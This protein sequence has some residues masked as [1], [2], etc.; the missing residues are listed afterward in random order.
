VTDRP[1]R[2][3]RALV[4]TGGSGASADGPPPKR[5]IPFILHQFLEYAVGVALVVL[6]VHLGKSDLLLGAGA[7]FGLLAVTAH[8]PL[9]I[10]R[11]C[12][13][14][15]HRALDVAVAIA[16]ALSPL[17]GTLRPGVVGIVVVELVAVAWLRVATLTRY[18]PAATKAAPLDRPA[19]GGAG[20]ADHG[21]SPGPT[22]TGFRHLGRMTAGARSRL[23]GAADALDTGARKLGGHAGRLQRAWRRSGR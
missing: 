4:T 17:V 23:P 10:V 13:Q 18:A 14:R 19:A 21:L 16:L 22:P 15:L 3:D 5:R 11:V 12:G 20:A 2:R 7:V 9:G 8:G 1:R 6:S